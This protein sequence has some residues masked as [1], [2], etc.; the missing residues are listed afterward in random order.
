L[1]VADVTSRADADRRVIT[2]VVHGDVDAQAA[3]NLG[4]TLAGVIVRDRPRHVVVDLS[5]VTSIDDTAVGTL[6]AARQAAGDV[7][8]ELRLH[9]PTAAL[10][11][12]LAS[13]GLD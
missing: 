7:D 13:S 9:R 8:V 11:A 5:G 1:A 3:G 2:V 4:R 6:V 12:M 10:A